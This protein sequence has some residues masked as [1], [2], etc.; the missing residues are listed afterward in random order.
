MSSR[1]IASSGVILA[2]ILLLSASCASAIPM[3]PLP[4]APSKIAATIPMGPLPG[5]PSKIAAIPM[6]PLP[7]APSKIA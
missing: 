6:G 1:T 5:A 2:V 3:G 4:G 7:G